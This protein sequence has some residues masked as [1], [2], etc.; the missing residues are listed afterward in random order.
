MCPYAILLAMETR[1]ETVKKP[2]RRSMYIVPE[3]YL[4]ALAMAKRQ[5]ISLSSVVTMLLRMWLDGK[6]IPQ[7]ID[8]EISERVAEKM[9]ESLDNE[10]KER[11]AS[12]RLTANEIVANSIK[13]IRRPTQYTVVESTDRIELAKQ[14]SDYIDAKWL[15]H[16]SLTVVPYDGAFYYCQAMVTYEK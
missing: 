4:P 1:D 6:V 10:L 5:K 7:L 13:R 3:I 2:N 12:F 11:V 15:P 16:G 9:D 8:E 14:I